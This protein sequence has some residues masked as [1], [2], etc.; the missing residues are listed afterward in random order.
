[1][2]AE[3]AVRRHSSAGT[4]NAVTGRTAYPD[5]TEVWTGWVRLQR[6]F[7][8]GGQHQIGDRQV[9]MQ[10]LTLS[11]PADASE[12]RVGDEVRVLSF[13]DA[14]AGDAHLVGRPL[15]VHNVRTGSVL[16]QRDLV[17]SDAP[18]TSR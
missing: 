13:R 12:V 14:D 6:D 7:R 2:T 17:V 4:F 11:L 3:V 5:P 10:D 8:G 18:V 16:W 1:M 15:W 9:A